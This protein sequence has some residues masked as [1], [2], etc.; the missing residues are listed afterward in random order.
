MSCALS[1][2]NIDGI[3]VGICT[4]QELCIS[5]CHIL[6]SSEQISLDNQSCAASFVTGVLGCEGLCQEQELSC[7]QP[8]AA[9]W[10]STVNS[11]LFLL[12]DS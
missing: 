5:K 9:T 11:A 4:Q 7:V 1:L 12:R 10:D 2:N 8:G 6:S 3:S